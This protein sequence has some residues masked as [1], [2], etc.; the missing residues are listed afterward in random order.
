VAH[1]P[2]GA[3]IAISDESVDLRWWPADG[4]PEGSDDALAHLVARAVHTSGE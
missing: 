3:Q 4:L 1:A 2:A